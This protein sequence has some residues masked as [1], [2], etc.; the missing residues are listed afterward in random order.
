[1]SRT[2]EVHIIEDHENG[3]VSEYHFEE[4][5]GTHTLQMGNE[6]PAHT[7]GIP[8]FVLPVWL[9]EV[10]VQAIIE[11]AD[12]RGMRKPSEYTIEGTL[13][14]QTKHLEDIK[15]VNTKLFELLLPKGNLQEMPC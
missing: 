1:M 3:Q 5:D 8:S 13:K 9:Y 7:K 14:A 12:H 11:D 15:E 4:K 2:I 6:V 10:L